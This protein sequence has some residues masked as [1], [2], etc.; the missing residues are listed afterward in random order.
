MKKLLF[1]LFAAT[2]LLTS[3]EN[4]EDKIKENITAKLK[5]RMKDP[6]SFEFVSMA[7]RDTAK[8]KERKEII[9][10]EEVAE[11]KAIPAEVE[12]AA[13]LAESF[14]TEHNFLKK[15]TDDN[16][17]AIYFV[18]FVAKG[19]NTFGAK[20]QGKYQATVLND[21]NFTVVSLSGN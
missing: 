4:K 7:V 18:D 3:C 14:E 1:T 20:I 6:D 17:D 16:K 19:T 13:Q 5:E 2:V 10:A 21:E 15:Q 9:T 11:L 8:V 12:G